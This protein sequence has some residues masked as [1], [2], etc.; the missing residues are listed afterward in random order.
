MVARRLSDDYSRTKAINER[1]VHLSF[2][3][4]SSTVIDVEFLSDLAQGIG[5]ILCDWWLADADFFIGLK[6]FEE[7]LDVLENLIKPDYVDYFETWHD[8]KTEDSLLEKHA[9]VSDAIEARAI[10]LGL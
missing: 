4:E 5:T 8:D 10:E 9:E 3:H 1:S 2:A 7:W 6:A